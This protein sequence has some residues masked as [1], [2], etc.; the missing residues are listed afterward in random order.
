M[1]CAALEPTFIAAFFASA[2][3]L[4]T[5]LGEIVIT[6]NNERKERIEFGQYHH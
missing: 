4:H 2:S 3:R 5:P 6:D 1:N